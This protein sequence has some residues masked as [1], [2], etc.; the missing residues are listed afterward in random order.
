MAAFTISILCFSIAFLKYRFITALPISLQQVVDL[1][2]DGYLVV[3]WHHCILS[4]NR[5][6]LDLFPEPDVI[7]PGTNLRIFIERYFIDVLSY[8]QYLDIHA[9]A[10][11]QLETV[12]TEMHISGDVYVSLE[13]T[14]VMLRGVQIGNIILLK[15]ITQSKRLIEVTKSE[16]RYKSEFLSNMSHEIRTPM[17]AIIG[18]VNIGKSAAE[19]ERKNY[20]LTRIEDASK[21][22]LGLINDILDMSK[23]EAGKFELSAKEFVFEKMVQTVVN[24]VKFRAD[25]KKQEL[26]VY[27]DGT[28][29]EVLVGDDQRLAQVITNLMGNAIKFTPEHG[30]IKLAVKLLREENDLFAIQFDVIDTG[31]GISPE[32]QKRLFQSFTQAEADTSRKYG[33]TGLGLTISKSLVEKMGGKIWIE[34][35]LGK[36]TVFSFI[37]L[38]AG[39][40]EEKQE[41][42]GQDAKG[43]TEETDADIAGLFK[44]SRILLV[45]DMEINREIVLAMLEPTLIKIDCAENG[46]E[47][48]R[49]FSEAPEKYEMIF[50]DVQMPEMDGYEATRRIRALD[51][52]KAETIPIIAM[53]ANVFREDIEKCF[54]SGMNGHIGKP[55]DYDDV[56]RLL[57]LH[58]LKE[59]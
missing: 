32:Q 15:D 16:S 57:R 8:D 11:A 20:C 49:M 29:P 44:G 51:M 2:S 21:H 46:A 30:S 50:M 35:E 26:T 27:I 40:A 36:G 14:P 43:R 18:M 25:E 52:P 41:L 38:L 42:S 54:E 17:N 37:V 5:A 13:I 33:G 9:R 3:D 53:T 22:L 45:E 23:I 24:V 28:I 4:Y 10:A 34:S 59:V 12:S 39:G 56:L 48:V 19:I 55:L 58:V 7:A 1:I 6:L 47:S 31:I